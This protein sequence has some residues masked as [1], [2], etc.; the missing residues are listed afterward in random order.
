MSSFGLPAAAWASAINF[1]VYTQIAAY[2]GPSD[3]RA[4]SAAATTFRAHN[5]SGLIWDDRIAKAWGRPGLHW[6]RDAV[7]HA[8]LP[9]AVL[10][11]TAVQGEFG[12]VTPRRSRARFGR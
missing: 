8:P 9:M 12:A 11:A 10:H 5:A 1:D 6:S 3:L 4:L 2:L 7:Y